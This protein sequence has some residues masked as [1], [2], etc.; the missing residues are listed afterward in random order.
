MKPTINK[1]TSVTKKAAT[2]TDLIITNSFVE[3]AF[4]TGIIKSD[5]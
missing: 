1:A 3:N 4:K 5:V 2:V